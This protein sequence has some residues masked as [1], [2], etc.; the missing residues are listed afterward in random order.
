MKISIDPG[1]TGTGICLWLH[2][3]P[4]SVVTIWPKALAGSTEAAGQ[5]KLVDL[6]TQ[7]LAWWSTVVVAHCSANGERVT[8]AAVEL[9]HIHTPKKNLNSVFWNAMA[10]GVILATLGELGVPATTFR[11]MGHQSKED[12]AWLAK[13]FGLQGSVHA[14]DAVHIGVLQGYDRDE[15]VWQ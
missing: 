10:C 4:T 12:A 11:K 15:V 14:H 5:M 6:R 3:Q 9:P 7:F 13:S 2:G 1:L 8:A